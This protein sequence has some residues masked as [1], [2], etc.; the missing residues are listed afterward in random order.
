MSSKT[1]TPSLKDSYFE[2]VREFPLLPIKNER[3]YDAA[4]GFLQKLAIRDEK[5]LDSGQRA[6]VAALTQFV[7]DY[8]QNRH[9]IDVADLGP[10]DALQYLMSENDMKAIDLG[11]LLG[12][13]SVA[14]QILSGKRELSKAHILILAERFKV[15]PGLFL[16]QR[17][18]VK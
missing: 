15:E 17:V 5:S 3:H 4:L 6:Y 18:A 1:S 14:S 10:L 2:L 11:H 8:E 13:R 7:E 12:S 16:E 9:R